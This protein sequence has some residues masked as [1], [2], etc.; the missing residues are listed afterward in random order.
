MELF[1]GEKFYG[2]L[3]IFILSVLNYIEVYTLKNIRGPWGLSDNKIQLI[4]IN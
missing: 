1:D 2:M 3:D 4:L